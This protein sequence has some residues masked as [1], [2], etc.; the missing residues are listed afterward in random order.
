MSRAYVAHPFIVSWSLRRLQETM[1]GW[2]T[3]ARDT[4]ADK[5]VLCAVLISSSNK[6]PF[7]FNGGIVNFVLSPLIYNK[8]RFGYGLSQ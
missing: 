6:P 3:Y 1:N 5:P 8:D 4:G 7:K 2:A